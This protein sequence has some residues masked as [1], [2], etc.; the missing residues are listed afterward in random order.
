MVHDRPVG[1]VLTE[2][3]NGRAACHYCGAVPSWLHHALYFSSVNATLPAAQATAASRLRPWSV[4]HSITYDKRRGR[5]TGGARHRRQTKHA[6]EFQARI[7]FCAR[8]RSNRR[9]SCSTRERVREL[10]RPGRQ[11]PD[12]PHHG[13]RRERP[14]R[15]TARSRL[16]RQPAQRDL[17]AALPHIGKGKSSFL[18]ATGSRAAAAAPTGGA[19]SS[20][21]AS[22]PTSRSRCANRVPG[23]SASTASVKCF[24]KRKT[25]SRSTR[26]RWTPGAFRLPDQLRVWR[27]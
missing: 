12:G 22:A 8:P 6:I 2:P 5:A 16:D 4:V 3:H 26:T 17:R 1:A 11:E 15:R 23:A 27:E 10:E 13:R 9:G 19:A 21:R 24:R 20:R 25:S 18:R 14:D 7:I